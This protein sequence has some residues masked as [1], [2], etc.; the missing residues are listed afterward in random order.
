VSAWLPP[1][2]PDILGGLLHAYLYGIAAD[3]NLGIE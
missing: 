1:A 2:F 3:R